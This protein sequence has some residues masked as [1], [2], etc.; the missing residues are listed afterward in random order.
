MAENQ[1]A[2]HRA[3]VR[4]ELQRRHHADL[5]ETNWIMK[6]FREEKGPYLGPASEARKQWE[7]AQVPFRE[8][9]I[10]SHHDHPTPF[11]PGLPRDAWA[12]SPVAD[13]C[14][15]LLFSGS[16]FLVAFVTLYST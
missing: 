5:Q 13:T 2:T 9:S 7:E 10:G 11:Y 12:L 14:A 16:S 1:Y 3:R 6:Y 8:R 15:F 4:R